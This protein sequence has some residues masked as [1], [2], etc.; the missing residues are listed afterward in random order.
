[1]YKKMRYKLRGYMLLTG[2]LSSILFIML[3]GAYFTT[4][5]GSFGLIKNSQVALQAQQYGEIA[6]NTLSLI[7][8]DELDTLGA[9]NRRAI[10]NTTGWE[11]EVTIAPEQ[12]IDPSAE[13]KQRIATVK[14]YKT[15]DVL[16][17]YS[18]QVP[19]SSQGSSSSVPVG[20]VLW[21]AAMTPPKGFL[22][23]NGQSTTPY[24]KLKALI[25]P[26]VP[27]LRGVFV[28]GLDN[29][30]GID[31]NRQLLSLQEDTLQ[32]HNHRLPMNADISGED[33]Q[34][35][36]WN[37][38]TLGGSNIINV[39]RWT[40]GGIMVTDEI[41]G[42]PRTSMETRPQNVALLPCIKHD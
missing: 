30:R 39:V 31:K 22:E 23:C 6:S 33:W 1:M 15:G 14:I 21:F 20:T 26:T 10:N 7:T 34:D 16:P 28:R 25:G 13:S 42:E 2:I 9:H 12:I 38:E 3:A 11:D 19:L 8:Y 17:R 36:W 24:A 41:N 5:G 29:G 35:H 40:T 32:G 27:D 4:L 18:L 37:G